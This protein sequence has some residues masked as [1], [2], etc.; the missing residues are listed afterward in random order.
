MTNISLSSL[1]AARYSP[2][3]SLND[4]RNSGS[5]LSGAIIEPP[6]DNT[7]MLTLRIY[8]GLAEIATERVL[9]TGGE[10]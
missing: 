5:G 6:T 10:E 1:F 7:V 4:L 9:I 2:M 3:L 8:H